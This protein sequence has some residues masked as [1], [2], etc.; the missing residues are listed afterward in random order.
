MYLSQ[1]LIDTGGNPDRP[2][3]G[4]MWLNNIYHVH[5]RLSMAFGKKD[6]QKAMFLFRIDNN[7][8][9]DGSRAMILVQSEAEP[10]W[11][12]AFY[13]A[14]DFLASLPAYKPYDPVF[15][16]GDILRY[17]LLANPTKKISTGDFAREHTE[18]YDRQGRKR[19]IGK[20][21]SIVSLAGPIDETEDERAVR[22]HDEYKDWLGRRSGNGGFV[23]EKFDLVRLFRVVGYKPDGFSTRS[24]SWNLDKKRL[25]F[26]AALMEGI[27]EVTD[28]EQFMETI[29]NGIGSAKSFG[30]GLLSVVRR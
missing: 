12:E 30:F 10:N 15:H 23:I 2:R 4:R 7:I 16:E 28:P 3:P 9:S 18:K 20:R 19:T 5:Q 1:L 6:D 17:R 8:S 14:P 27:L 26:N 24:G 29:R 11:Q 22:L 25:T 13:N 21:V